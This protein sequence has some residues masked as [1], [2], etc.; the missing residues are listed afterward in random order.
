MLRIGIMIFNA[1]ML[2]KKKDEK[3]LNPDRLKLNDWLSK[4]EIQCDDIIADFEARKVDWT[5]SQFEQAFLNKTK[6]VGVENY[7]IE[8][9]A[10]LRESG[11]TGNMICY[12]NSLKMIKKFDS[13]FDKLLF[14]ELDY[15]YIVQFDKY[16]DK[17]NLSNLTKKY[18]LKTVRAV[19]NRAIKDGEATELIYP[20]GKNG[21]SIKSLESETEKRYLPD[22]YM[23]KIKNTKFD[24][25]QMEWCRNLFLFSY[26]AQGMAFVDMAAL[27]KNNIVRLNNGLYISYK[28]QKVEK[29]GKFIKI[30]IND[31]LQP[32]LDYFL[33][34]TELIEDYLLPI[35]SRKNYKGEQLYNHIRNRYKRYNNH[36]KTLGDA[37]ALEGVRLS[38]YQSRH[39]FAMRLKN[40]GVSADVISESMGHHDLS[41]T[42]IYLDSFQH[43]EVDEANEKL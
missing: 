9:I 18:Y 3:L 37:L 10:D 13:K 43:N 31:N 22:A 24:K 30:K 32:I 35:V 12:E 27:T 34:E 14:S 29:K 16:L 38:S 36:L 8:R 39:T 42:K 1:F 19:Y 7:W 25:Y 11:K 21:F 15:K 4:K 40:Q 41:T 5:L 20:F 33:N 28:R 23:D 6:K 17:R 2:K 26:Y